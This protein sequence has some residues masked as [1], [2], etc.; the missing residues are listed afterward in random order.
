MSDQVPRRKLAAILAADVVGYSSMMG[1]DEIRTLKNLKACRSIIDGVIKLNHGRIFNTAGDSVIAEFAS[2]VEAIVAAVEFQKNLQERN[3]ICEK[4]DQMSF[5]VGLNL[6]DVIVE[7]ENLYGEGINV[8]ARIESA[9][10]S[11]GISISAKFYEEVRR[12]LDLNFE[13]LG[14]QKMK[15][16]S[17]PVLTYKVKL[18]SDNE[19]SN[20]EEKNS[21]NNQK[22]YDESVPPSI[23]VLPFTNMSGDSEQEYFAD[24]ITEDIITNLSMW[25]TFPV[26]SRNSSFTYKGNS[27]KI[28]DV[29]KD[30]DVSYVVEGSVRKS[31]NRVRITAQLIEAKNDKHIWSEKWDRTLDDIFEVQDEVSIAIAA[32]VSP[33]VSGYEQEN[34]SKKTKINFSAWDYYLKALSAFNK[35]SRT[36]YKDLG[37][38]HAKEFLDLAISNDEKNADFYSL[39]AFIYTQCVIQRVSLDG[40]DTLEQVL[41][42]ARRS[43]SIDPENSRALYCLANYYFFCGDYYQSKDYGERIVKSNPSYASGHVILAYSK[44]ITGDYH[45][46]IDSINK[47]LKLSPFDEDISTWYNCLCFINLGL[48]KYEDALFFVNKALSKSKFGG[49]IGFKAAILGYLGRDEEA[50]ENLDNYLNSRPQLKTKDDARNILFKNS[51]LTEIIIEG[52]IMAGWKPSN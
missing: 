20:L 36:D 16:I 27:I 21:S 45:D 3:K 11:G 37:L 10:E 7:G 41:N 32:K 8:A 42:Y 22:N 50:K 39:Y 1:L 28:K 44:V 46:A 34:I 48:G 26:V 12:K 31:G 40:E 38:D 4:N 9:A 19:T 51:P 5:R 35:R 33:S 43:E 25:K 6:G 30:L 47:A 15:N 29:S 52:L 13:S 49:F 14:E 23:V 24:G 18:E 2:P 17:D